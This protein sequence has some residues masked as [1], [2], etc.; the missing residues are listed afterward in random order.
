MVCR[1]LKVTFVLLAIFLPVTLNGKVVTQQKALEFATR[2]FSN[3]AQ[4]RGKTGKLSCVWDSNQL[5][6]SSRSSGKSPTFYVFTPSDEKG[7]VIVAGDDVTVPVIGYSFENQ[8]PNV[9]ELPQNLQSWLEWV[10]QEI[11]YAREK[12]EA[13]SLSVEQQWMNSRAAEVLIM[14]DTP[15]W[16]QGFPYNLQCPMDGEYR[17]IVGC[18]A[19]AVATVMRYYQWPKKGK[20]VAEEYVAYTNS[21]Q[22]P[23]RNLEHEYDWDN[24]KMQYIWGEYNDTEIN[25]VATLMADVATAIKADFGYDLTMASVPVGILQKH[26]DYHPGMYWMSRTGYSFEWDQYMVDEL[27][28]GRPL[29]YRGDGGEGTVGHLFV[30][31]GC[32]TDS[33]FH[34]NWGWGGYCDGFFYLGALN[35]SGR[36]YNE[37]QMVLMNMVPNDGSGIAN[38]LEINWGN[39]FADSNTFLPLLPFNVKASVINS[40]MMDF[41]GSLRLAVTDGEGNIKEWISEEKEISLNAYYDNSFSFPC[42]ITRDI[43]IGDRIRLFYKEQDAEEWKTVKAPLGKYYIWEIYIADNVTISESTSIYY[44]KNENKLRVNFKYGVSASVW[45]NDQPV[46]KGIEYDPYGSINI[47]TRELPEGVYTIKLEKGKEK[48][49]FTFQIKPL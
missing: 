40:K 47:N 4:S 38:W 42:T 30:L 31:D 1:F 11:V 2:F 27:M 12:G 7:F 8:I 44:S 13:A 10:H 28:K 26:F 49:E 45:L 36:N 22:V 18:T 14:L 17:S 6:L 43:S 46:Y 35:P 25:A 29:L 48:K 41:S 24:M 16:N 15:L 33:Y 32:T 9:D 23:A 21:I 5:P 39:L 19:V 37:G 34:V 3:H 20:G